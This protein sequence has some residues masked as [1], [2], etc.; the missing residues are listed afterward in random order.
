[1]VELEEYMQPALSQTHSVN[2]WT[3][4]MLIKFNSP[5]FKDYYWINSGDIVR[6]TTTSHFRII[7]FS[8]FGTP[9]KSMCMFYVA[10]DSGL[11]WHSSEACHYISRCLQQVFIDEI[12]TEVSMT[13]L[14]P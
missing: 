6:C 7:N 13:Y 12:F 11:S 8:W 2:H 1:M 4:N 10:S 3:S 5:N 9:K 14:T